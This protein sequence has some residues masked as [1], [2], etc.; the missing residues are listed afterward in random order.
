MLKGLRY[1]EKASKSE[2]IKKPMSWGVVRMILTHFC[3]QRKTPIVVIFQTKVDMQTLASS[4]ISIA[5][6]VKNL[7]IQEPRLLQVKTPVYVLG[8]IKLSFWVFFLV[9][10]FV[11]SQM[12]FKL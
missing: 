8:K 1:F 9:I 7:L 4:L 10:S 6:Q 2:R 11:F 3:S 12:E 5:R